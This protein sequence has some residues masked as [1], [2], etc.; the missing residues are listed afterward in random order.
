MNQPLSEI[1]ESQIDMILDFRSIK[2]YK[3]AKD[4]CEELQS[5][6]LDVSRILK[7]K[8]IISEMKTQVILNSER[9]KLK[10]DQDTSK[11]LSQLDEHEPTNKLH[12]SMNM[13]ESELT[14]WK[15]ELNM[16]KID[17]TKWMQITSKSQEKI[18]NIKEQVETFKSEFLR[19]NNTRVNSILIKP[20]KSCLRLLR[21]ILITLFKWFILM[22]LIFFFVI[23]LVAENS[24]QDK[25]SHYK[26]CKSVFLSCF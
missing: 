8:T 21:K 26:S 3:D 22:L 20:I 19:N 17:E 5:L 18:T 11:A 13:S 9:M 4:S 14:Q 24:M 6:I 10:I 2:S 1:I 12:K 7:E 25:C 15:N 23:A 16:L